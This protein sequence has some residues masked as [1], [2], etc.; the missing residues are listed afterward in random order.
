MHVAGRVLDAQDGDRRHAPPAV[1]QHGK[2][3]GHLQQRHVAAAQGQAQPIIGRPVE[4]GDAHALR[5]FEKAGQAHELQGLDRRDVERLGQRLADQHRAVLLAVIVPGHIRCAVG[6]RPRGRHIPDHGRRGPAL[7]KGGDVGDRLDRRSRLLQR[8]RLVHL[9]VDV[10]VVKVGAADHGQDL[11]GVGSERYQGAVGGLLVLEGRHVGRDL[12]LGDLLQARIEGGGHAHSA[13]VQHIGAILL[14]QYLVDPDDKVGRLHVQPLRLERDLLGL[15]RFSLGGGDVSFLG[16]QG[17][18]HPLAA[19]G[20]FQ[21]GVGV[22]V[23][24]RLGQPGQH[25]RLGQGQFAGFLAESRSRP[26]PRC[27][28]PGGHS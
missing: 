24:R 10:G 5:L 12:L 28:R 19:L 3:A 11:A 27:R 1:V 7:L 17:Q 16:H 21:V 13:T 23:G 2:G 6:T 22:P 25:G 4:R 8:Q 15:G 20:L 26:R 18:H 9:A 14:L